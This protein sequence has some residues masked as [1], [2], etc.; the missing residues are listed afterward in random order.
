MR[1]KAVIVPATAALL[2][3]CASGGG[4]GGGSGS[5]APAAAELT[6]A[7]PAA[8]NPLTYDLPSPP[9]AT[10]EFSDTT[11]TVMN[12]D[13]QDI[14]M[15]MASA[16]TVALTYERGT[17][18]LLIS[19]DVLD[20][21]SSM[22][23]GIMPT[24]SVG[25]DDLEGEFR[26]VLGARGDVEVTSLPAPANVLAPV[27][28][29]QSMANEM[30]PRF[31]DGPV[32][33]GDSWADTTDAS[34]DEDDMADA[35]VAGIGNIGA[36]GTSITTYTL[37]GDTTVA[38]RTLLVITL[39]IDGNVAVAGEVEGQDMT[40][41]MANV[42]EGSFLWDPERRLLT[43]VDLTRTVDGTMTTQG[44]EMSMTAVGTVRMR[45]VN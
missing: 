44:M 32:E 43:A 8:D 35:G 38:G 9:T 11:I 13:G 26:I 20:F 42:T 37:A 41:D 27:T 16:A 5:A 10:Y 6:P 25:Q 4:S 24:M 19:G 40:Q 21:S 14:E 33:V 3:A 17:D 12:A 30:F 36:G 31:P 15:T 2:S 23:S 29:F 1:L 45:L 34:L 18:G 7:E 39:L 22:S 28:T